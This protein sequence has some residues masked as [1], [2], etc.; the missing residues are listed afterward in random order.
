MASAN[1]EK[2]WQ[3]KRNT[4]LERNKYMLNNP[5]MSDIKFAFP[6]SARTIPAHKYVLAVSSPVFFAMF[7][8]DLAETRDT[9]NII[10][11]QQD[12]FLHFLRFIYCDEANFQ[13]VDTAIEVWYLADK[14]DIPSVARE[15]VEFLDGNMDP[16]K[17][18]DIIDHAR[19]LND[20]VLE[21]TCWQVIDYNAQ[22]I[23][24][25][26]SFLD[27]EDKSLLSEF[28]G[29]SSL[30]VSEEL[31]LFNA[32]DRWAAKRCQEA[33]MI[34]NG[35]NKRSVL[36]E[37]LLKNIRFFLMSPDKFT[38]VVLPKNIL[39]KDEV[40]DVFKYYSYDDHV[41]SEIS[42]SGINRKPF[43][44]CMMSNVSLS[45]TDWYRVN[46]SVMLTFRSQVSI[47]LCGLEFL[48]NPTATNGCVS[49]A[50]W[51]QGVKFKQLTA[52][53]RADSW[54]TSTRV[55]ENKVFFN[56]PIKVD[57]KTCYTIE[58]LGASSR[59]PNCFVT[60]ESSGFS[61]ETFRIFTE[62]EEEPGEIYDEMT[63]DPYFVEMRSLRFCEG[64]FTS[65]IPENRPYIGHIK[66]VIFQKNW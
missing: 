52:K 16:L 62:D 20:E 8:G 7:Y 33:G 44:Y 46:E 22:A 63:S 40:I 9:I 17:A 65:E 35:E 6:D 2:R 51:R 24:S 5:L 48:F 50:L 57:A 28:L 58:L 14:Y 11:C 41:Y 43:G 61:Q 47:L 27:L 10:D 26:D 66:S 32:I 3:A 56:R 55:G 64:L 4:V 42:R 31:T 23:I 21:K 45:R 59:S 60:N 25:D 36:G 1:V 37:D 12:I 34:V 54:S 38:D 53:S 29:R 39:T 18:F 15:C 13:D 49:L 30:R 19:L